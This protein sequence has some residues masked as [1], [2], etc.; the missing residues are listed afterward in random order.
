MTRATL[1]DIATPALLAM[2]FVVVSAWMTLRAVQPPPAAPVLLAMLLYLGAHALRVVRMVV[3]LGHRAPSLRGIA[4]AHALTT[5]VGGMLPLKL[6][7]L[8]RIAALGRASTGLSDGLRA[9]W[10]ERVFDA[11]VLAIAGAL[12]LASGGQGAGLVTTVALVVLVATVALVRPVP[13]ALRHTK[14]FLIRRYTNDWSLAALRRIDTAARWLEDARRLVEGRVAT[15]GLLTVALWSMEVLAFQ[16]GTASL[17]GDDTTLANAM[18]LLSDALRF[19]R[20][21]PPDV[22]AWVLFAGQMLVALAGLGLLFATRR[23]LSDAPEAP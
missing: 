16:V 11:A 14:T 12:V 23:D 2:P 4:I 6:G 10:I 8:V 21:P 19:D 5:P 7:E 1:R 18:S 13:E 15:L 20:Y 22:W 17:A 3:L 9:V